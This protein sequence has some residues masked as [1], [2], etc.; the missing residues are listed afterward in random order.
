MNPPLLRLDALSWGVGGEVLG[1][2]LDLTIEAGQI[3]AL[4]G[5]NG[6]GKTSLLRTMLGLIPPL[7]GRIELDARPLDA[8]GRRERAAHV[9]YVAQHSPAAPG[10]PTLDWVLLARTARLGFGQ[11]PGER[12]RSA[13][14]EALRTVGLAD[15][16]RRAIDA[17]SGGE[18]Q[19][20]AIARALAQGSRLLLL[21][22]PSASLDFGNRARVDACL[23]ALAATGRA[24][25]LTTHDPAQAAALAERVALLERGGAPQIGTAA[26]M[27]EP[28]RLAQVF[29]VAPSLIRAT[30]PPTTAVF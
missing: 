30:Q 4:M 24:V 10:Y 26:G 7:G 13:A 15:R 11:A 8:W 21:D 1:R 23:R 18:R 22:E 17:L 9:G 5:P 12:D 29:G 28:Q 6:C 25:V 14:L 2:G 3:V 20:A 27:L 16:A 19:L